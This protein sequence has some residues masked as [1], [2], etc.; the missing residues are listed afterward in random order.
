MSFAYFFVF[1]GAWFTGEL[2]LIPN[3]FTIAW[4]LFAIADALW[5]RGW[6]K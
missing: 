6:N 4:A 2:A 3:E 5:F 1:L